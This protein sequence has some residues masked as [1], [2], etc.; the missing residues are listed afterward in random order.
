VV[1]PLPFPFEETLLSVFRDIPSAFLMIRSAFLINFTSGD[2][3][4]LGSPGF[5]FT[6]GSPA[7]TARQFRQIEIKI[8]AADLMIMGTLEI[9]YNIT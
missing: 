7:Y 8:V 6:G 9:Q 5:P 2:G 1:L 3:A 4:P